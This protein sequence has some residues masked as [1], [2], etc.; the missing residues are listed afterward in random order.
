MAAP[1]LMLSQ[2][3]AQVS[4]I[5]SRAA[6]AAHAVAASAPLALTRARRSLAA[7]RFQPRSGPAPVTGLHRYAAPEEAPERARRPA[8]RSFSR[9]CRN[10]AS[11]R[12]PDDSG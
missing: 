12:P 3:P 4:H 9:E 2:K 8:F 5:R 6:I 10:V 11:A 7:L 1:R